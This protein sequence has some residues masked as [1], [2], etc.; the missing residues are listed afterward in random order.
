MLL[1]TIKLGTFNINRL[2]PD[3]KVDVGKAVC[4][5]VFDSNLREKEVVEDHHQ[6][7]VSANN[8]L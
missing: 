5:D 3:L 8:I 2:N 4:Q 7:E 1:L 6:E